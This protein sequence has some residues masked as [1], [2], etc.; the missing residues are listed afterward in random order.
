M[1]PKRAIEKVI[2]NSDVDFSL[3]TLRRTFETIAARLDIPYYALKKLLNHSVKGDITGGY[4][5]L[6]VAN[7]RGPMQKIAGHLKAHCG[8]E[9]S[10]EMRAGHNM[11]AIATKPVV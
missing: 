5:I 6:D 9:L 2:Q 8:L 7:L 4:V 10:L 1:G 11:S 3:H